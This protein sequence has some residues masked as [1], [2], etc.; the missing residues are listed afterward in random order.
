MKE[1]YIK[2][3]CEIE[4]FKSADVITTSDPGDDNNTPF[5]FG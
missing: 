5:P 4:Q 2:P 1:K 3:E